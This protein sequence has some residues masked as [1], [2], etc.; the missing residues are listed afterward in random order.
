MKPP[1]D[2]IRDIVIDILKASMVDSSIQ[3][4]PL[5]GSTQLVSDLDLSS[6]DA[7]QLLATIDVRLGTKLPFEK[8]LE[9]GR[10]RLGELTINHLA[11]FAHEHF[12]H[13]PSDP[14]PA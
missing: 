6:I 5:R 2:E 13:R 7:L 8:L 11:A 3:S 4:G 14:N 1:L 9:A 12:D 10:P